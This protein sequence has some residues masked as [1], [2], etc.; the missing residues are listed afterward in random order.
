MKLDYV[1]IKVINTNRIKVVG[2]II[3]KFN[4]KIKNQKNYK[5][6]MK[7]QNIYKYDFKL[8]ITL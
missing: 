7:C 8:R 3:N 2:I 1:K 5:K 4:S 6:K